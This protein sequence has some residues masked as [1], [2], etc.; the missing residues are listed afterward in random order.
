[1]YIVKILKILVLTASIFAGNVFIMPSVSSAEDVWCYSDGELSFYLAS[2][3]IKEIKDDLNGIRYSVSGRTVVNNKQH[4]VH[5]YGFAVFN[6]NVV[7]YSFNRFNGKWEYPYPIK[8][9]S[10]LR[11]IWQAMKPYMKK[12]GIYYSDSWE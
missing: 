3:T 8:K 11:A 1:M 10:N 7:C 12:K 9:D 6:D 2:D 5:L 4:N